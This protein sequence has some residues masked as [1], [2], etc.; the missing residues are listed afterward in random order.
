MSERKH[1]IFSLIGELLV[2]L[3]TLSLF[4]EGHA[5][6]FYFLQ[7][8]IRIIQIL[9]IIGI[10]YLFFGAFT[11]RL[12]LR[13]S[14]I[15]KFIW[16][17]IA[18]NAISLVNAKWFGRSLKISL[19]LFSL[20]LLYYLFYNLLGARKIYEKAFKFLIYTGL[21]QIMYGLYQVIAGI[22]NWCFKLNLPIGY[23][24]LIHV[25][26]I[27]SPWGRPY[28]TLVEPVWYGAIC[29]FYSLLFFVLSC[30]SSNKRRLYS[31]SLNLSLIGLFLSFARGAWLGFFVALLFSL[32]FKYKFKH[33]KLDI[34]VYIKN[35]YMPL[36]LIFIII[37][38]SPQ[39]RGIIKERF[40]PS[41]DPG[42]SLNL[43][44]ARIGLIKNS[45]RRF[46]NA[47]TE[48]IIK[49]NNQ[50]SNIPPSRSSSYMSLVIGNGPGSS[51]FSYIAIAKGE[52]YAKEI[53]RGK[54]TLERKEDEGFDPSIISTVLSDTG[55][56]G[57]IIF[58]L[59]IGAIV[60]LNF[61][62]IP[63][64]IEEYQLIGLGSFLGIIGLFMSYIFSQGLWIPFT[65]VF[66]AF[67]TAAFKN[68]TFK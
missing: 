51:G 20:A 62:T 45:M 8:R 60:M 38:I 23:L 52:E 64:L 34:S 7:A 36:V 54:I 44:N 57:L 24:G 3:M 13:S 43:T 1:L 53:T 9:E 46:I 58:L 40:H 33:L 35:L 61:K 49:D 21:L 27:G 19:L 4:F 28:A 65:W 30:K 68:G 12:T 37:I 41:Y 17:Y 5:F 67:N 31:L 63:L 55:I 14:P 47:P 39:I 11:K 29:M 48:N 42:A 2:F 6:S 26:Y 32:F 59:L 15:D 18:I 25:Q 10:F 56:I 50:I 22:I 16:G 66:L